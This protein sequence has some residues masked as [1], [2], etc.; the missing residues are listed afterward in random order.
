MEE[1]IECP[2]CKGLGFVSAGV[3]KTENDRDERNVYKT[4][5]RCGGAKTLPEHDP[6]LLLERIKRLESL[7]N[8]T[9]AP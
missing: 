6:Q 1:Q 4:C 7:L 5:S 8:G 9:T 2:E 3:E